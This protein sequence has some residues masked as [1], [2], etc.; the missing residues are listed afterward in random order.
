MKE[1]KLIDYRHIK[2]INEFIKT[3]DRQKYLYKI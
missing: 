3:N 1:K 2:G